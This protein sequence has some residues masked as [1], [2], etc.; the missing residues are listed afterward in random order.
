M[1]STRGP[2]GGLTRRDSGRALREDVFDVREDIEMVSSCAEGVGGYVVAMGVGSEDDEGESTG[3]LMDCFVA[4]SGSSSNIEGG[5]VVFGDSATTDALCLCMLM[6]SVSELKSVSTVNW[7]DSRLSS[8]RR[9]APGFARKSRA[10][11]LGDR[12][13][14]SREMERWEAVSASESWSGWLCA[15]AVGGGSISMSVF[16]SSVA[17]DNKLVEQANDD[18]SCIS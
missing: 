4:V 9:K 10:S 12:G 2:S 13:G 15:A 18:I 7:L 6:S 3:A 8:E 14:E 11:V 16:F 1:P 5:A 17:L